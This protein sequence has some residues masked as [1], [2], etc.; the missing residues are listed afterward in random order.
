MGARRT[1]RI[2]VRIARSEHDAIER[3]ARA[4][5]LSFSEYVRR[6]A[7]SDFDRP[8]IRTDPEEL[9]K[10]YVNLRRSGNLLNQ[11]AREL[12]THHRPDRIE[13]ELSEAF[14]AVARAS[15]DV[16]DFIA[17]ARKSV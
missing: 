12:N 13:A 9:R 10:V 17:D 8:V 15:A 7:L 6:S 16:S 3:R 11:C 14:H 4:S 5:G 1:A 2:N